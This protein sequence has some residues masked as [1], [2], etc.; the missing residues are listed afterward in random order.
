M[1]P[2]RWDSVIEKQGDYVDGF[3]TDNVKEMKVLEKNIYN[4]YYFWNGLRFHFRLITEQHMK[5]EDKFAFESN[6]DVEICS[7]HM[8]I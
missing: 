7:T 4:V 1:L 6:N 2:R 3:W 8:V 5:N